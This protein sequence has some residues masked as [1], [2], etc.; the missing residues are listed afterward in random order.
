MKLYK[1]TLKQKKMNQTKKT[2]EKSENP[3][4]II[5]KKISRKKLQKL[6]IKE[7][8]QLMITLKKQTL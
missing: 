1:K 8:K 4:D 2:N 5:I 6:L 7:E 3:N